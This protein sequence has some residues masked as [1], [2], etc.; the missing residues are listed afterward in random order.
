[1]THEHL[2]T[3]RLESVAWASYYKG[4]FNQVPIC[5]LHLLFVYCIPDFQCPYFTADPFT[6]PPLRSP[7]RCPLK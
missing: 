7:S 1:M 2:G 4:R 6:T 5:R 3:N